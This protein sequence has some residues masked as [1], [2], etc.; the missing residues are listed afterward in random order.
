MQ[1][2]ASAL[3]GGGELPSPPTRGVAVASARHCSTKS[4]TF[5]MQVPYA[6][7]SF[8]S[9]V[10]LTLDPKICTEI[11]RAADVI[12]VQWLWRRAHSATRV[13]FNH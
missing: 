3:Y 2:P 13:K 7:S 4:R 8:A 10:S 5:A 1:S 12:L 11:K 9:A 6:A